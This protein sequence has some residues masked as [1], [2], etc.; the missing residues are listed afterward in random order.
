MDV[1]IDKNDFVWLVLYTLIFLS[2]FESYLVNDE[3]LNDCSYNYFFSNLIVLVDAFNFLVSDSLV[4][5]GH[6]INFIFVFFDEFT[7]NFLI[8]FLSIRLHLFEFFSSF[9]LLK[10]T[11]ISL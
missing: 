11:N 6:F 4:F 8:F 2:I 7:K 3:P 9:L 1:I 5:D 10:L